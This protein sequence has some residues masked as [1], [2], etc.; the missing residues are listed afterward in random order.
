M[1]EPPSPAEPQRPSEPRKPKFLDQLRTALRTRHYSIRTEESY[2]GWARR[3]ILFHGKQHPRDLGAPEIVAFLS[4]LADEC[5]VSASTQN[6]AL[7]AILFLYRVVLRREI[8]DLDGIVRAR[9][10]RH[11]P[12]VL[13]RDEV[14][15]L[16]DQLEGTPRIMATL[17]YG[18]GLRLMECLRLRVHDIDFQQRVLLIREG[19]GRKDRPAL[20]P[21][22]A[23]APLR[24]HLKRV[25]ALHRTD[26]ARGQGRV[27]LP[28]ALGRKLPSAATD[29]AWQ[30]V[31]PA[32]RLSSDPRTGRR[33]RHHL[34][35]SVLQRAVSRAG[36]EAGLD[37]R[38]TC[39]V[40]RHSFATHL[41]EDGSDIR[42][43]QE[44]LGHRSVQ[45]TMI[46]THVLRRGPLAVA[47]P[48]DR[49]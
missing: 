20:L 42:T 16:L 41:L 45:T 39:H 9:R 2:V 6:Q 38:V 29:W 44:L 18:S 25:R 4:N 22:A 15:R 32:A 23:E 31:F 43:V 7:S 33:H 40:L 3:F 21:R 36:V 35:P 17:L 19:K 12:V 34:H 28:Y 11:L 48:A 5:Q 24:G 49:L 47:S 46:Y 10:P 8:E 37:K 30:W 26:L 27:R 1:D 13:S 14:R